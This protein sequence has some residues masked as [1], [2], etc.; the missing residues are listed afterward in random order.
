M[1]DIVA[2]YRRMQFQVN[3]FQN[4]ENSKKPHFGPDLGPLGPNYFILFY[5]LFF[6]SK[7]WLRQPLVIMV[8]HHRKTSRKTSDPFLKKLVTDGRTRVI[9]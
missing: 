2:S 9:S 8:S 6:F 3:L 4:Q 7:I 1:L 5:F